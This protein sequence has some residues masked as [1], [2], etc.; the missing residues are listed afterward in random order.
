MKKLLIL[1]L[2]LVSLFSFAQQD[3]YYRK[4]DWK[5]YP[6]SI[7]QLTDST[8]QTDA[9]PFDY[10]DPGSIDRIVG[11]YVV[12]FVG[13]RYSV[14]D[15]TSTTVTVLDI[16]HTGQAP[17]TGQLARCYRSVGNG[18]AKY[19]GSIDY[20]PLDES[21]RWKLNGS[22]NELLWRHINDTLTNYWNKQEI[23]NADTTRWGLGG[24]PLIIAKNGLYLS[25]DTVK[26]GG[27]LTENTTID[28]RHRNIE[29][30]DNSKKIELRDNYFKLNVTDTTQISN[31]SRI[32]IDDGINLLSQTD[33]T[34]SEIDMNSDQNSTNWHYNNSIS[35]DNY[36]SNQYLD[37]N[38]SETYIEKN[39]VVSQVIQKPDSIITK[40]NTAKSL[41]I[42]V[43]RGTIQDTTGI[44]YINV[45]E[46][47]FQD[48]T[49]VTKH[50]VDNKLTSD[51]LFTTIAISDEITALTTG[52]SKVTFRVP[53]ACKLT[54]VRAS[55][56]TAPTGSELIFDINENG[57]SVLSTKLSI[58]ATEKVSV[59]AASQP[60]I[61]D[62][63]ILDYSE[64]TIDIDQVGSTIA[65]TGAKII[66]YYI[67]N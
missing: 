41:P 44:K 28:S 27:S 36:N 59:T 67:K 46:S 8:Y 37:I 22:D 42:N 4:V 30:G 29:V 51:T 56:T 17:Q 23:T 25:G 35:Y 13:H 38:G 26:L 55:V 10:N 32:V 2:T 19:I 40:L 1:L 33:T 61:S 63:S 43:I 21:A 62:S 57:T 54:K 65:G 6:E 47:Y 34:T 49:L 58:D 24:T 12:D 45:I 7:I 11:N 9:I 64:I 14:I 48:Q 50:Y 52:T 66:I 18:E 60:V 31:Y 5:F 3:E 20:S 53:I 16:Y 15:S 39:D